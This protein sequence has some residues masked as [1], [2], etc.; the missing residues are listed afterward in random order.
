MI[1]RRTHVLLLAALALCVLALPSTASAQNVKPS[2]IRIRVDSVIATNTGQGMDL[3]LLSSGMAD[4]LR[5]M[6]EYTTYRLVKHQERQTV[7]GRKVTF[8]M[9]GGRILH[10]APLA[11]VG[12]MVSM[13][14]VLFE[15]TKP[16]MTTDLRLINHALL[17]VGGP[18][19]QQGMLITMISTDAPNQPID[20]GAP[21]QAMP[22]PPPPGSPDASAFPADNPQPP[23]Q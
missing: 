10:I 20:R 1:E 5:A 17:V 4:R 16:V 18:H 11:V 12:N 13:E 3:Q 23:Q 6:F 22:P 8:E 15:G 2:T 7:C 21:P 14:L 9:P 19:Y